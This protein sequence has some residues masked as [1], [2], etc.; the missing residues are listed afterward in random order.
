MMQLT[1]QANFTTNKRNLSRTD[2]ARS[3]ETFHLRLTYI[4]TYITFISPRIYKS[5]CIAN[6]SERMINKGINK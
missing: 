6:F 1:F 4:H 5:S 3:F 2:I